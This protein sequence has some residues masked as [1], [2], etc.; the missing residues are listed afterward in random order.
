MHI[1]AA[2]R[3]AQREMR[4]GIRG[5]RVLIAC[6]ALGV[7][8][9][10]AIGTVGDRIEAGL[11]EQG[12]VL[13][14]GDAEIQLSYR[15]ATED[16]K[17]WL[18]AHAQEVSEIVVF[19]SM[20]TTVPGRAGASNTV[21]ADASNR[22]LTQIKAV[23]DRYPLYGRTELDPPMDLDAALAQKDGIY[24]AVMHGD[25]INRLQ[26]KIGDILTLGSRQFQL[27]ARLHTEP[28]GVNTGFALGPRTIVRQTG[29]EDSGLI[30]PGSLYTTRYRLRL[31]PNV[32]LDVFRDATQTSLPDSGL[33]W[34][35]RRNGSPAARSFVQRVGSFLVLIGLAGIAV[36]GIGVSAAVRTYLE[37]KTETIATLKT[38]GAERGT[39]F[40][41]YLM[42]VSVMIALGIA[43]GIMIGSLTPQLLRPL[44][45]A[46]L[47]VP[48]GTGFPVAPL[49][50][51]ALY[52]ALTGLTFSLWSLSKTGEVKPAEL[53]RI[54]TI[55]K[56]SIPSTALL[57]AIFMCAALLIAAASWLSNA[58]EIALWTAVGLIG[59][60]IVLGF[61]AT[62]VRRAARHL[63]RSGFLRNLTE[64]RLAMG[65]IG[66]PHSD[67][68]PA[69]LS[70]GL[71]LT[72]LA[73]VGQIA[74]N[75]ETTISRN[76]PERAP[77]Y[78]VIDIQNHQ[79]DSFTR[80]VN[81]AHRVSQLDTAPMLRGIISR[82]N[83]VDAIEA[84]GPHWVL[85]GDRGVSYAAHPPEGTVITA[86]EWWPETYSGKPLVSFADDEAREL[87]LR[88]NDILTLNILG[89]D[90][91][92]Q[93]ANFREVE[94]E[95]MGIGFVM[96]V[97]PA[98]IAAAPHTHI[99]TIYAEGDDN[100]T[101]FRQ[102]A[103]TFPN[104]TIISVAEGIARAAQIL[105]GLATA[106]TY[107]SGVTLA[108]GLVVLIGTAA[109]GERRRIYEA[110]ILK[111]LGATRRRILTALAL[112]AAILGIAAG[113]VATVAGGIAG[114][115]VLTFVMDSAYQF[116]PIAAAV[117][118]LAGGMASLV[119]S[120]LFAWRPLQVK[121]SR[122]LRAPD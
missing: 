78:F 57:L 38:L 114:W 34:V 94:F 27:R 85:R 50:E 7:A 75:L 110:A 87:G 97:N 4:G 83:G 42:Q 72:I 101:L 77:S 37:S 69:I 100:Q 59:S 118:V 99:A 20:A 81:S 106:I 70:L 52:G 33:Q 54:G 84:A 2:F 90:I 21:A 104:V 58:T 67:A 26:L 47:P 82:I 95:S 11:T 30:G 49:A 92:V 51:A 60:L 63:G 112:R 93:V 71:G 29:L 76:I 66:G 88:I 24:G 73:A 6:L 17:Q 121:P 16:E 74:S 86:G 56:R 15:F 45:V 10:A 5:F 68:G 98:A 3:I 120:L 35:D 89:R 44:L 80:L 64:L 119:A 28:D 108:T 39:I 103:S 19:R 96:I 13:L 65:S 32:D 25:L 55:E 14:G 18:R 62:C 117:I 116:K 107:G 61:M 41:A 40:L 105:N 23:D 31:D 53:Y 22:A 12:A 113:L 46:Q 79:F 1:P 102:I 122:I 111:T 115:A 109:A 43:L 9:V 8:S 48:V 36:G 91:D